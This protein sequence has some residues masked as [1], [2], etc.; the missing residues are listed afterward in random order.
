[1]S[2]PTSEFDRVVRERNRVEAERDALRAAIRRACDEWEA[3]G[4]RG[5]GNTFTDLAAAA[6]VDR[7]DTEQAAPNQ[8]RPSDVLIVGARITPEVVE[9]VKTVESALVRAAVGDTE[10][11]AEV[12]RRVAADDGRRFSLADV[13]AEFEVGDT[14]QADEPQPS[15]LEFESKAVEK[16]MMWLYDSGAKDITFKGCEAALVAALPYIGGTASSKSL[17]AGQV[18]PQQPTWE[19]TELNEDRDYLLGPG[20]VGQDTTGELPTGHVW[21]GSQCIFCAGLFSLVSR[22]PCPGDTTGEQRQ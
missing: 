18:V 9:L 1:M 4:T 5:V 14:G 16:L 21:H 7:E 20:P 13:A 8:V 11:A 2:I 22:S 15:R 6:G 17:R 19:P 12:E 3:F 10:L